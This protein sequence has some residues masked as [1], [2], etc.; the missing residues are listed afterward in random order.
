MK[1]LNKLFLKGLIVVMPISVSLYVFLIA[2]NKAEGIFAPYIKDLIGKEFYIPGLGILISFLLIVLVGLLVSNIITGSIISFL[3]N[4][5]EKVPLIKAIYNP[6]K[7]LFTLFGGSGPDS[8]KKVVLVTHPQTG[9]ESLGLVTREEFSDFTTS[10]EFGNKIAVYL[11]MSYML[12]GM[13]VIVDRNLT[14]EIDIPVERALKLAITG[15]IK[16]EK[17]NYKWVVLYAVQRP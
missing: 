3:T 6:L 15:W 8:M 1:L 11:P 4:S 7:D 17:P 14:R 12:G 5:L 16:A 2:L 9:L 13:T 10:S